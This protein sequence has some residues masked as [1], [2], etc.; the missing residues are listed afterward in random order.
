MVAR[1]VSTRLKPNRVG[2]F[3]QLIEQDALPPE[4]RKA[5]RTKLRSS[6]PTELEPLPLLCGIGKKARRLIPA[7]PIRDYSSMTSVPESLNDSQEITQAIAELMRLH[8]DVLARVFALQTLL[9]DLDLLSP[10][11]VQQR[12]EDFRKK[13]ASDREAFAALRKKTPAVTQV[14]RRQRILDEY[15]GS[16]Q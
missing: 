8:Y 14:R 10:H 4:D 5:S 13:F 16:P 3:T 15:E 12:T 11:Q 7:M 9:Q 6:L 1:G 2:Q